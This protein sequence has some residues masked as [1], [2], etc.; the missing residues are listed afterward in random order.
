MAQNVSFLEKKL[1]EFSE[2]RQDEFA[3]QH[4]NYWD[5]YKALLSNLRLQIYPYINP[6]LSC[7]S[8]S[9]GI[10]TDHGE[11]H[12]DEVVRYAGLL[13]EDTF[14][15]KDSALN[16]YELYLLLCAI[17]VHDAG[18]IDGR[19]D[20]E[21]QAYGILLSQ[22]GQITSDTSELTLIADI[23]Q[24]H[25]GLTLD[26][27]DKDTIGRTLPEKTVA[28]AV[29]VRPQLI[30][31]L[32]RFA[33]EI[34][35]HRGRASSYHLRQNTLPEENKLF[36]LYADG[37]AG[38]KPDRGNK[39]FNLRLSFDTSLFARTYPAP[40]KDENGNHTTVEKYLIDD[41]WDR[42]DKLNHERVYCNRFLLPSM[43]TD[44]LEV[45]VTFTKKTTIDGR[46]YSMPCLQR[47]VTIR[48]EG[49]PTV[50]RDWR[51]KPELAEVD[52][53]HLAERAW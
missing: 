41:V 46:P 52:G 13:I 40:A 15:R 11:R 10:Y 14:D 6:G 1:E 47:D 4:V 45:N 20:H 9:P 18:N 28:G 23:A 5:R 19:D 51:K 43:Q 35:E 8:K 31:A 50:S 3:I 21:K 53:I 16:P 49:Y 26:D 29:D 33:D 36:H 25:G 27:N 22:G 34:C 7:L 17:R 12:F 2:S 30:A 44:R 24:A 37:I 32:V 42:V 48:D 39:A 38:A